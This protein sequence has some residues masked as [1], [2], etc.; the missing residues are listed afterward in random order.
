[1][2]SFHSGVEKYVVGFQNNF[3]FIFK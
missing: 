1:L 3:A 2:Y